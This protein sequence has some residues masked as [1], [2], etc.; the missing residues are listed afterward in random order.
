MSFALESSAADR[1]RLRGTLDF[2]T[3][4]VAH[5]AGLQ[6]LATLSGKACTFDCAD[7]ANADSAGL[8]VLLDWRREAHQRG[9]ALRYENMPEAIARLARISAVD[10]LLA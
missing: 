2:S 7:L 8:A 6:A 9:I 5:P 10:S 3:A 4:A 1:H